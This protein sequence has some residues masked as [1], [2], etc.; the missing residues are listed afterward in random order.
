MALVEKE[1]L[2]DLTTQLQQQQ[3]SL[4]FTRRP[5]RICDERVELIM[6]EKE[7]GITR[8]KMENMAL[9]EKNLDFTLELRDLN[10]SC[11]VR[12]NSMSTQRANRQM[13]VHLTKKA[14]TE[15]HGWLKVRR[16]EKDIQRLS[17]ENIRLQELAGEGKDKGG[18]KEGDKS[19][20]PPS[21]RIPQTLILH[22]ITSKVKTHGG[23]QDFS[24]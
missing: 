21:N 8:A 23:E 6:K 15:R 13:T 22:P 9:L 17:T 24:M 3:K 18:R 20:L 4:P 12:R 19:P 1:H 2:Q 14:I 10:I 11:S 5:K 7:E 16:M